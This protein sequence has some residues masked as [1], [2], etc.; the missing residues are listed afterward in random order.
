[1]AVGINAFVFTLQNQSSKD[2]EDCGTYLTLAMI[3]VLDFAYCMLHI[4]SV[5][6]KVLVE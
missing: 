2:I 3:T 6:V 5:I 1:M 4:I